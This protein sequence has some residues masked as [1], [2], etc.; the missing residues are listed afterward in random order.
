MVSKSVENTSISMSTA[1]KFS[2]AGTPQEE[3]RALP[4]LGLGEPV[5]LLPGMGI[6]FCGVF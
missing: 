3:E 6:D 4:S 2:G 5:C 1:G